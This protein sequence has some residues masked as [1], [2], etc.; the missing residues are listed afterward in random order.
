MP[1]LFERSSLVGFY[2]FG[3]LS[4][5]ESNIRLAYTFLFSSKKEF[6]VQIHSEGNRLS[7]IVKFYWL[8]N[9]WTSSVLMTSWGFIG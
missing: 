9:I 4:L 3:I 1:I 2:Y 7:F 5:R 6:L 8:K